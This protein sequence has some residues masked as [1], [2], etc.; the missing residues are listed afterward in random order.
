M[1]APDSPPPVT[2]QSRH[3]CRTCSAHNEQL[4]ECD[5]APSLFDACDVVTEVMGIHTSVPRASGCGEHGALPARDARR[6]RT[7][8]LLVK[9]RGRAVLASR[10]QHIRMC[11]APA[12][13]TSVFQ[14]THGSLSPL[15]L[16][17]RAFAYAVSTRAMYLSRGSG[18]LKPVSRRDNSNLNA[19]PSAAATVSAALA[20]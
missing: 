18:I 2:S 3:R 17:R 10:E 11:S 4:V 1:G 20:R 7:G 5:S 9:G 19:V 15:L 12:L 6:T 13:S 8:F 14:V 16:R